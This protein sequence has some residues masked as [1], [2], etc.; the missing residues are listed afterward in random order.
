MR[1]LGCSEWLR[2][3]LVLREMRQSLPYT[4]RQLHQTVSLGPRV[5][6]QEYRSG[7]KI[8]RL[9]SWCFEC[10]R[11]R[12]GFHMKSKH[13]VHPTH[14]HAHGNGCGHEGVKHKGRTG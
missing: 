9:P 7:Q 1:T 11:C 10:Y 13:E 5:C 2:S 8:A 3:M 14:P 4:L 12:G 6:C